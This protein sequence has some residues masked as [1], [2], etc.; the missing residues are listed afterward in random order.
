MNKTQ[1]MV[2]GALLAA[3]TT[4][5]TMVIHIPSPTNGF[6]NLG[7]CFVLLA[8][9]LLGPFWG[10]LAGGIGSAMAD[11]LLGYTHYVP[12]TF[13]IKGL[14]ALIAA[15]LFEKLKGKGFTSLIVS[16]VVGEAEMVLGYFLFASLILGKGMARA[17]SIPG[18]VFQATVGIIAGIALY[19]VAEKTG[20]NKGK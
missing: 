15:V 7:D 5:A 2:K 3:L 16:S 6:V 20:M 10:F 12:G 9:W 19:K 17:L 14:T 18:N 1:T 11:M 13:I 4:V 8:G